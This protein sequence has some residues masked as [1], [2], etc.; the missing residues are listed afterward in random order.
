MARC[1]CSCIC[2][3][4]CIVSRLSD[5]EMLNVFLSH[6]KN[7]A[8]LSLSKQL[9]ENCWCWQQLVGIVRYGLAGMEIDLSE[10][11]I[12]NYCSGC[13]TVRSDKN[14]GL[15][16]VFVVKQTLDSCRTSF[17][18][19]AICLLLWVP[20]TFVI[21]ASMHKDPRQAV[22]WKSLCLEIVMPQFSLSTGGGAF[23]WGPG[24]LSYANVC[25]WIL[26]NTIS[27]E[28]CFLIKQN[29]WSPQ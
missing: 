13:R 11:W 28:I 20:D 1:M 17:S 10:W 29:S 27:L 24:S 12:P 8:V 5:W 14:R 26:S 9:K 23:M 4:G 25:W 18:N 22:C 16:S 3:S 19:S 21:C 6:F 15:D 2:Y 7:A